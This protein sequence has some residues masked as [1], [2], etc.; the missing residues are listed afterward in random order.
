MELYRFAAAEAGARGWQLDLEMAGHRIGEHP[1]AV[2]HDGLLSQADFTPSA[3][4][5]M[6]E[7][8]LRHPDLPYSAFIEDLLLD[9]ADV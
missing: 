9:P 5:W 4:L 2:F 7:I 3:G 8:Q 1:H 6:L